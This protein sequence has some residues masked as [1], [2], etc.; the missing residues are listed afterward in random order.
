M[1]IDKA[2]YLAL[3]GFFFGLG[4]CLFTCAPIILP[5]AGTKK[6]W[7][8]GVIAALNFSIGR[9]LVYMVLGGLF[10]Y[11]GALMLKHYYSSGFYHYIQAGLSVLLISIGAS[12]LIG[13][14][15]G[16]KFCSAGE[17]S[18]LLLGV[19]VGLSP[20]VPL[21]GILIEIALFS[22]NF[23][24]GLAYSFFFGIGTVMSPLLL[25]SAAVPLVGGINRK[26]SGIFNYICAAMMM[27]AGV[28]L[29]F[30]IAS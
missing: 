3:Q 24:S 20:C 28:Y 5:Y 9:L 17:G 19:L 10:G 22:D 14:K 13:R 8:E 15:I 11:F 6:T 1:S 16:F 26:V 23:L 29:L 7:K 18:T 21:T 4:P 30:R 2:I 27:L 25:L 12:V